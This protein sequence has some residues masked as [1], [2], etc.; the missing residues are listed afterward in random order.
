MAGIIG[1]ML[2]NGVRNGESFCLS[3][4]LV[5]AELFLHNI[6]PGKI[7]FRKGVLLC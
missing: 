4:F 6:V 2:D 5:W 7:N 1:T 3:A